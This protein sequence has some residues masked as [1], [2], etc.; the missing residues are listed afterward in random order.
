MVRKSK[1]ILLLEA[2][3]G[4][5]DA[6]QSIV[7]EQELALLTSYSTDDALNML[8]KCPVIAVF[9]NLNCINGDALDF[10]HLLKQDFP[11]LPI[12]ALLEEKNQAMTINLLQGGVFAC[13]ELPINPYEVAYNVGKI[14][15]NSLEAYNPFALRYEERTIVMPNDFSLVTPVAKNLV[16]TS[17]PPNDKRRYHVILGLTEIINNA[18][19]HG[20]LG[21]S[22]DE[23]SNAL[24]ASRFFS[25][26]IERAN[27]EPYKSRVVTIRARVYPDQRSTEYLVADQGM[28]FDWKSLPDPKDNENLLKRHGRGILIAR[29]AFDEVSYN[30]LGNQVALMAHLESPYK[31]MIL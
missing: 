19:E 6:I 9:M 5:Q 7:I 13:L 1:T 15:A 24:K 14:V 10:V 3:E 8:S 11:E 18:I 2:D 27:Q 17:I 4:I 22:S 26:A 28:G 16:D 25:L 23:K 12:L 31:G 21:I 29:Y 20:N 30:D